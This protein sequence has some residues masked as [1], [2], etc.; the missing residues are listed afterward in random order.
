MDGL[1]ELHVQGIRVAEIY[2]LLFIKAQNDYNR[3]EQV[4]VRIGRSIHTELNKVFMI[5]LKECMFTNTLK[6]LTSIMFVY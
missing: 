6:V 2:C 5:D 3:C 1:V 4:F